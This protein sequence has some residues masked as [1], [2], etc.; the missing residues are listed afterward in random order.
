M[1]GG[2]GGVGGVPV[3]GSGG[4]GGSTGVGGGLGGTGGSGTGGVAGGS[5]GSGAGGLPSGT[6]LMMEP[7]DKVGDDPP[8]TWVSSDMTTMGSWS[9]AADGASN[10][11]WSETTVTSTELKSISGRATWT[12]QV[13]EARV[14]PTGGDVAN[15]R[16]MIYGRYQDDKNFIFLEFSQGQIKVRKKNDGSSTD[17]GKYKIPTTTPLALNTWYTIKLSIAGSTLT[18]YFNGTPTTPVADI[19]TVIPMGGIG[20]GVSSNGS[21]DFDD[22]KVTTP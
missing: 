14:R 8:Y 19:G 6:V 1:G 16:I 5:G 18:G 7:F 3:T 21:A 9:I 12:D 11:V 4:R 2:A 15:M 20:V 10:H 17:I 13:I 22:V